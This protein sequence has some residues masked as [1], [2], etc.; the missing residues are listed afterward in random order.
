MKNRIFAAALAATGAVLS[1]SAAFAWDPQ[2]A[3]YYIG[4]DLRTTIP[5]G[6]YA[7]LPNPN[8]NRITFLYAHTYPTTPEINHYH[9]KSTYTY[10]GPNLGENTAVQPFNG[11]ATGIPGNFLP[12]GPFGSSPRLKL[13]PGTGVFAGQWVS[14]QDPDE[15]FGRLTIKSVDSLAGA[16][17][18]SPTQIL[19]DSS[20][21]RWNGLIA[22][23]LLT[24]ELVAISPG[25]RVA[26][27]AG[28]TLM[29]QPGDQVFLGGGDA[30]L[31]FTPVFT[32]AS[33][34][35]ADHFATFKI[36]DTGTGNAGAAF[37]ES[38]QFTFNLVVPEPAALGLLAPLGILLMRRRA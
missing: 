32:T 38:G 16:P 24:L 30:S 33:G 7:G 3:E 13:L 10:V 26:N 35:Q 20:G 17:S 34:V 18:G 4:R 29:T 28:A 14:G 15:N 2:F 5:T 9:S 21:G 8:F 23:S 1:S 25:L 22:G 31:S 6:V 36:I 11:S 27:T 37:G 19:F 12:E